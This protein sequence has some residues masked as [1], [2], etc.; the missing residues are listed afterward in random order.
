MTTDEKLEY[1]A[2]RRLSE[3]PVASQR[4]L[5]ES[6]GISLGRANYVVRALVSRGLVTMKNVRSNNNRLGYVYVL[7]PKGISE[8]ALLTRS[9]LARKMAEY[10]RLQKEID[11]LALEAG[12][13]DV[14]V[15]AG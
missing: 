8:K 10:D 12:V 1:Q 2:L 15:L 6:L 9:F 14:R 3:G 7:T 5:A 11:A 4:T 13:S